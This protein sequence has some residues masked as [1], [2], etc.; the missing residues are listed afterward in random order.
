MPLYF[1]YSVEKPDDFKF[2]EIYAKN[3]LTF[4]R[5]FSIM[6]Y[7]EITVDRRNTA[8]ICEYLIEK[9]GVDLLNRAED[10]IRQYYE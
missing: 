6:H 7:R 5:I 4:H 2:H 10:F 3:M 8:E 1:L 9:H